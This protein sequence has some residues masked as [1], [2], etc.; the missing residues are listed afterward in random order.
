M[1]EGIDNHIMGAASGG[2]DVSDIGDGGE[3]IARVTA[4]T[5]STGAAAACAVCC[6]LPLVFPA[7]ALAG[8]GGVLIWLEEAQVVLT[9]ISVLILAGAWYLVWTQTW[10]RGLRPASLTLILMGFASIM[11]A[12]ALAWPWIEPPLIHLLR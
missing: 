2:G 5:A 10:R 8:L 12:V 3:R 9:P 7:I 11:S 6:V 1:T 4:V